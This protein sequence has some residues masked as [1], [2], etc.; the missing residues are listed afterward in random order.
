V[1]G[2]EGLFQQLLTLSWCRHSPSSLH[3]EVDVRHH[4]V[5]SPSSPLRWSSIT[6][7]PQYLLSIVMFLLL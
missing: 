2:E 7:S 1:S 3:L 4:L 6:E 5:F